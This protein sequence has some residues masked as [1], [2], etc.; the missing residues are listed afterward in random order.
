MSVCLGW[1]VL[2]TTKNS[3]SAQFDLS[4]DVLVRV[5]TLMDGPCTDN[6]MRM[7]ENYT[8]LDQKP[9]STGQ[10]NTFVLK[11]EHDVENMWLNTLIWF[12]QLFS[13]NRRHWSQRFYLCI[14]QHG[15]GGVHVDTKPENTGQLA[16][17]SV[18]LV[19]Q[20]C[21]QQQQNKKKKPVWQNILITGKQTQSSSGPR[22]AVAASPDTEWRPFGGPGG[23][24]WGCSMHWQIWVTQSK[25]L[26]SQLWHAI[27]KTLKLLPDLAQIQLTT[28]FHA[29]T[30]S[31]VSAW[32]QTWPHIC[33]LWANCI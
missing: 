32:H 25:R 27:F 20:K 2:R 16:A 28:T 17:K 14:L 7:S 13:R 30:Q 12:Y 4:K 21:K 5:Y 11:K 8:Q 31:A 3:Y 23:V 19:R 15:E 26:P 10:S 6:K 24:G 9:P 22:N 33:L 18:F 1:Q 29:S